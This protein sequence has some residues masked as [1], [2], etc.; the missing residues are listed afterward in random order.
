MRPGSVP[1]GPSHGGEWHLDVPLMIG[2][3]QVGRVRVGGVRTGQ[4]ACLDIQT[5]L[6]L[7]DSFESRLPGLADP[8]GV[9]SSGDSAAADPQATSKDKEA[10]SSVAHHQ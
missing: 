4:P 8:P 5:L 2:K 9:K 3:Q 1:G 10:V 7:I 6:A